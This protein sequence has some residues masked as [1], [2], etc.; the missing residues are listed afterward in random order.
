[1]SMR[2]KIAAKYEERSTEL[3]ILPAGEFEIQLLIDCAF[4]ALM[5][6]TEDME[7][8]AVRTEEVESIDWVEALMD[9][10]ITSAQAV[11]VASYKA[12]LKAAQEGK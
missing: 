1:M 8:A 4:D 12:M 2:E 3:D 10:G 11:V 6:P 5:E 7:T 9:T